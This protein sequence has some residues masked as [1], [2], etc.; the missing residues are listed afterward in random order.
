MTY[1][2]NSIIII[3]SAIVLSNCQNSVSEP[4]EGVKTGNSWESIFNGV[5]LDNW[6]VKIKGHPLGVNWND[7]FI[8]VDSAIRVN[9]NSYTDFNSS[10]GHIFI[11]ILIQIIN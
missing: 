6:N 7:T 5:N 2:Y 9:Y 8:V 11:R 10:F 1:I 4:K 3:A